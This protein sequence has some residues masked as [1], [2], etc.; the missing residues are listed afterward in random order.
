LATRVGGLVRDIL[1][2][3]IGRNRTPDAG[4]A[5]GDRR[6]CERFDISIAVPFRVA[7][8]RPPITGELGVRNL[9]A[10]GVGLTHTQPIAPGTDVILLLPIDGDDEDDASGDESDPPRG[11]PGRREV[12]CRIT[13]CVESAPGV[14][15]LGA[16]F[17]H[18]LAGDW[19]GDDP[20][21]AQRRLTEAEIARIR[22]H[23]LDG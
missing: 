8:A 16:V 2:G 11:D 12:A 7:G 18:H 6:A 9:S 17:V 1:L 14:F 13:R 22:E 15:V 3:R 20:A 23:I 10:S 4:A 21:A 5:G 19:P